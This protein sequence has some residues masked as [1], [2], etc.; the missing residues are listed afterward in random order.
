MKRI[1]AFVLGLTLISVS[2][3]ACYAQLGEIFGYAKDLTSWVGGLVGKTTVTPAYA[4]SMWRQD[5]WGQY[6]NSPYNV[7]KYVYRDLLGSYFYTFAWEDDFGNWTVSSDPFSINCVSR[8][9]YYCDRSHTLPDGF[10]Q[11]FIFNELRDFEIAVWAASVVKTGYFPPS[12]P[13]PVW[14]K[15]DATLLSSTCASVSPYT[16]ETRHGT[17]IRDT[18]IT[19][20]KMGLV[21]YDY[22]W[23][24]LCWVGDCYDY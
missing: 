20:T 6:A 9:N 22:S 13:Y 19:T 8:L 21:N 16:R 7:H 3:S 14:L 23:P 24:M 2:H 15:S 4:I 18:G 1:K 12:Q 10:V 11:Y 5:C 17:T